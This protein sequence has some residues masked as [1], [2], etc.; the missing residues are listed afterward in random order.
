MRRAVTTGSY[1]FAKASTSDPTK[2]YN[3]YQ[4]RE[5]L[6]RGLVATQ[7][8]LT[9]QGFLF[10]TYIEML[11]QECWRYDTSIMSGVPYA[12]TC[13]YGLSIL[14]IEDAEIID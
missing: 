9:Q 8:N 7:K 11:N 14:P 3:K 6:D 1:L 12:L 4:R 5:A 10:F 2:C 13:S